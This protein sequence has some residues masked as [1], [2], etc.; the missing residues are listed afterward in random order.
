M[1]SRPPA[2]SKPVWG[3]AILLLMAFAPIG[4]TEEGPAV[5]SPPDVAVKKEPGAPKATAGSKLT[6]G[7]FALGRDAGVDGDT[8]RLKGEPSV[9]VLGV[10]TEETFKE[11]FHRAAAARSFVAYAKEMRA[12]HPY[13]V[14]FG[15]PAGEAAATFVRE[16][17]KSITHIRLERDTPESRDFDTYGRR[18]GHVF[19][20]RPDG[21]L[22]LAEALIRAGHSPYFIKYGRSKRFDARFSAAEREARTAKRGIW[23]VSGPE[24]YPDYE[25]RLAWWSKRARLGQLWEAQQGAP[26]RVTLGTASANEKLAGLVGKRATVRGYLANIHVSKRNGRTLI[27]L[28]HEKRRSFPLVLKRPELLEQI[29]RVELESWPIRATGVIS[30]F[31]GRQQLVIERANQIQLR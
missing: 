16:L 20:L 28:G 26:D 18:L 15:T 3:I 6:I 29:R 4:W 22:L 23:S 9:R 10:D 31:K 5:A 2:V 21:D 24:H 11:P 19:L 8:I 12:G 14:K 17:L 13:P 25:E 30:L 1:P 27:F 7:R